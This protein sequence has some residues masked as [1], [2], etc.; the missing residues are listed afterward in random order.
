MND[1]I[2]SI[3]FSNFR[4][5]KN[6]PEMSFAPVTFLVGENNAGKSTII[7]SL[8]AI[9]HFLNDCMVSYQ[10]ENRNIIF[11]KN[12]Y[13][14][15]DR[16]EI[17]NRVRFG[18]QNCKD[19]HI[20]T[21]SRA[22]CNKADN[23]IITFRFLYG[24]FHF[25]IDVVE[26][27]NDLGKSAEGVV[28]ELRFHDRGLNINA[29]F[30]FHEN[31]FVVKFH[32]EPFH[33]D[34]GY[35][36]LTA[37]YEG[38]YEDFDVEGSISE[39]W[40]YNS[41]KIVNSIIKGVSFL[42]ERSLYTKDGYVRKNSWHL[43]REAANVLRKNKLLN[44]Q[45]HFSLWGKGYDFSSNIEY[46]RVHSV[47][48]DLILNSTDKSNYMAK[49]ICDYMHIAPL[50]YQ[51]EFVKE[52][53]NKFRIGVDF[54]I[55]DI[56]GESYI[57]KITNS[58]N[59]TVNLADKGTGAKQIFTL[60]IRLATFLPHAKDNT[61]NQGGVERLFIIEEPE[62]NL[63]PKLQSLL[64]DLF[65]SLSR[66]F[67]FVVETHSEYIIRRSQVLA[68]DSFDEIIMNISP[69]NWCN[70]RTYYFPAEGEPYDMEYQPNGK[71]VRKFNPGFYDIADDLIIDL[72]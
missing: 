20:G 57:V 43:S 66:K 52:W 25:E 4:R 27:N 41:G 9:D 71:F 28:K 72:I 68:R 15:Y 10:E 42:I 56:E 35:I 45:G 65:H 49:T 11:S 36:N 21:F 32:K 16:T 64:A 61:I 1:N 6:L 17:L 7:K 39:F 33:K 37:Y 50:P 3:G 44:N 63:H 2:S 54:D 67:R 70:F 26:D 60:L 69:K 53:M 30:N 23:E 62:Q 13:P 34:D 19:A 12:G 48:D 47:S 40:D 22:L 18:F 58:D 31:R 8:L 29:I 59:N 38:I 51:R 24:D 5:F 46:I 14:Q 55:K